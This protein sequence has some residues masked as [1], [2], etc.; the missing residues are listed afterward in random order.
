MTLE[1]HAEQKVTA[2]HLD[3]RSSTLASM[4]NTASPSP[5][6]TRT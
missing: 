6:R 2:R 4:E 3:S 1:Q 5:F